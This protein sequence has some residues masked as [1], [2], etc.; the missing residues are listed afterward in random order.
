MP[1]IPPESELRKIQQ[2][3]EQEMEQKQ[4]KSSVDQTSKLST[5]KKHILFNRVSYD[6]TLAVRKSQQI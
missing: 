1:A 6:G 2:F 4:I 5:N 3:L